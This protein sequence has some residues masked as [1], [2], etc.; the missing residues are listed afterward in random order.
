MTKFFFHFSLLLLFLDPR[1]GMDENVYPGSATL[2]FWVIFALLDPDP[3]PATQINADPDPLPW[4][5]T[6]YEQLTE[7]LSAPRPGTCIRW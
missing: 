3:D 6:Y 5:C 7:M 4:L 1:S 2:I